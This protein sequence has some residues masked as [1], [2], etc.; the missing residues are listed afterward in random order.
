MLTGEHNT[1][2]AQGET[3]H[4]VKTI[5]NHPN[6][7]GQ[8]TDYDYAILT[9]GDGEKIDLTD[10]ARAACLPDTGRFS[11]SQSRYNDQLTADVAV[12]R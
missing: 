1:S 9:I 7:N 5:L 3:R 11:W 6:Y 2:V 4:S 10:K 12:F 8:T